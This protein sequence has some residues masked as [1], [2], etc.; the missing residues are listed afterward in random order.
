M[1]ELLARRT[2]YK[3]LEL[4]LQAADPAGDTVRN[5]GEWTYLVIANDTLAPLT[6]R[7]ASPVLIDGL[8]VAS[9][10]LTVPAGEMR[11]FGRFPRQYYGDTL[12]LSYP[13]ATG[14]RL[15]AYSGAS[16]I[17]PIEGAIMGEGLYFDQWPCSGHL[18]AIGV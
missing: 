6:V 7:V 11:V 8:S 2:T 18:A 5:V 13:D 4:V 14:L 12:S 10:V 9:R 1:S 17:D 16:D 3:A 15:A